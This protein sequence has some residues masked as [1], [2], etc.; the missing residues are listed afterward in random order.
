[1]GIF[2]RKNETPF[3]NREGS[4]MDFDD[5]QFYEQDVAISNTQSPSQSRQSTNPKRRHGY[6]IE[7][8]IKLMRE[9]PADQ[10]Q[11]VVSIVERTLSSARINV[12][13]IVDDASRKLSR[14]DT[15]SKQLAKEIAELEAGIAQRR[16]EIQKIDA[17]VNETETVKQSFEDA[18]GVSN[19]STNLNQQSHHA[20]PPP[21][22]P[23]QAT[24]AADEAESNVRETPP[25]PTKTPAKAPT[26]A[27]S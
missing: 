19:N 7:D 16:S 10:R 8:A 26:P 14:L 21:P 12:K 6:S 1:M 15:R 13:D 25:A 24:A 23:P 17:D 3:T 20:A 5:Q 22:P 2:S 4:S 18:L 9:L 27:A 11:M